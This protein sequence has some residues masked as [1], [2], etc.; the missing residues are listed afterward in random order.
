M[1]E[2]SEIEFFESSVDL[3]RFLNNP[4]KY[5]IK[6]KKVNWK[7]NNIELIVDTDAVEE[8]MRTC[9]KCKQ[10][11]LEFVDEENMMG[12]F[13]GRYCKNKEC[14][15]S[16]VEVSKPRWL[17]EEERDSE[18]HAGRARY[19]PCGTFERADEYGGY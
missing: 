7:G 10:K 2:R 14:D 9:P 8:E 5:V 18:V 19:L 6:I 16:E 1:K 12:H 17:I 4:P 13:S 3:E 15:F 11:T